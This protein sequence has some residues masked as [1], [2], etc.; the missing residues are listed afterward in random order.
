MANY[1]TEPIRLLLK[2]QSW[3]GT[4]ID[5]DP[6]KLLNK[7]NE[8]EEE[9]GQHPPR[10]SRRDMEVN[11]EVIFE[12]WSL[13]WT[14]HLAHTTWTNAEAE[15]KSKVKADSDSV[16]MIFHRQSRSCVVTIN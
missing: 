15:R 5:P 6:A 14:H 1:P 11:T 9:Y 7:P 2:T 4:R 12:I 8:E 13:F 3:I 10:E 16:S